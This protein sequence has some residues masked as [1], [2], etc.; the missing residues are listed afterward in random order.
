MLI[1]DLDH[2]K[3]INDTYG[4]PFGDRC[5]AAAAQALRD[6]LQRSADV[7]ARYGGEEFAVLLPGAD[8]HAA[9]Q[10][11]AERLLHGVGSVELMHE[12]SAVRLACSIG[13]S[14]LVPASMSSPSSAVIEADK[15]LYLAKQQGRN[16][17]VM[18]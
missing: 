1:I 5:L 18:S 11:G 9:Q 6:G 14:T 2:F 8:A 7:L 15:A 3:K 17:V 4:H 16:R 12:G 13:V 10:R